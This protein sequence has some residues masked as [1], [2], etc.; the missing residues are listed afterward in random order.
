MDSVDGCKGD[1][2]GKKGRERRVVRLKYFH[3]R[4]H[5]TGGGLTSEGENMNLPI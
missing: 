5:S 1:S 4:G 3:G 2:K